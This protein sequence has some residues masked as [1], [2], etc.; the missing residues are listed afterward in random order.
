MAKKKDLETIGCAWVNKHYPDNLYL[1]HERS[2]ALH[3]Y[4]AGLTAK[5]EA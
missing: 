4:C 5:E 2:I 3:A 1:E